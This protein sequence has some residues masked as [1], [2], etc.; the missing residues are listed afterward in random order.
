[1][2]IKITT[3]SGKEVHA[4]YD[5][6]HVMQNFLDQWYDLGLLNH[7]TQSISRVNGRT[8]SGGTFDM[9]GVGYPVANY[10]GCP[11]PEVNTLY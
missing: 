5:D 8:D 2:A 11:R 6:G 7:I 10:T 4:I 9:L 3:E 1:M